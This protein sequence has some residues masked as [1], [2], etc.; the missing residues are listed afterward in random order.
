VIDNDDTLE[1]L[2]RRA[3]SVYAELERRA[4]AK[5]QA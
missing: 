2:K 1:E 5:E 4:A 3:R